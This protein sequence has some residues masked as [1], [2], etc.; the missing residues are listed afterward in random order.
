M[1]YVLWALIPKKVFWQNLNTPV[2]PDFQ[3]LYPFSSLMSRKN[4]K[5]SHGGI[6][7]KTSPDKQTGARSFITKSRKV[8]TTKKTRSVKLNQT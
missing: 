4:M 2:L 5:I 8:E 6:I 7:F 3:Q 1:V